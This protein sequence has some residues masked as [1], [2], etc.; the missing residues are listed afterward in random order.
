GSG[1][2][3]TAFR[4]WASGYGVMHSFTNGVDGATPLAGLIQ[5]SDGNFYGATLHGLG[6]SLGT[7]FRLTPA[8]VFTTLHAFGGGDDGGN[9]LASLMQGSDGNLYGTAST[10]GSNGVG[11]VF[12]LSTNGLFTPLWSFNATNGTYPAGSLVQ[13]SD[14]KLY[15]TASAG[16]THDL[17][18]VFSLS[19]N[20]SFNSLVSFDN[21]RGAY[22]SNG[23]VQ[24]A[25]GAFYGTA[26]SGGT[27]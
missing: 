16:G 4:V 10:G 11:T 14:G 6:A 20:G 8:N 3:G 25:D 5:A 13:G 1:L 24:A 18:T 21:T 2:Y 19:T 22:P 26:A 17:G 27:N 23:L 7:L 15:G 9:P 12:S